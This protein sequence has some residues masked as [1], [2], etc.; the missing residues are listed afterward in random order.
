MLDSKISE[1]MC[2]KYDKDIMLI[3]DTYNNQ[4]RQFRLGRSYVPFTENDISLIFGI[5]NGTRALDLKYSKRKTSEFICRRFNTDSSVSAPQI[6]QQL[7]L[8]LNGESETDIADVARLLCLYM[9]V[10]IFF[11]THGNTIGW[12]YVGYVENYM[13]MK[14]YAWAEE[15]S[16][17]LM[18]IGCVSTQQLSPQMIQS[19]RQGY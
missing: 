13:D 10:V 5:P 17:F 15:I 11:A 1:Q 12:A 6:K 19:I 8:A 7:H 18:D 16:K 3:L 2:R 14:H 4:R 9:L